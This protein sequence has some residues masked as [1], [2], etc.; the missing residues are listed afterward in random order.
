MAL[1][2]G[3]L[4][5]YNAECMMFEFTMKTP[6]DKIV[7]C[8]ISRTAMDYMHGVRGTPP[9]E[10]EAQFLRLRD[11][12]EKIACNNFKIEGTPH[13][14]MVRIFEK[15]LPEARDRKAVRWRPCSNLHTK[16]PRGGETRREG[17][18]CTPQSSLLTR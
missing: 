12:I 11:T 17:D 6:D 9:A 10:R 16:P 13:V 8:Q 7:A 5:G 3:S 1:T 4:I 2:R 18:D 15:H 14:G